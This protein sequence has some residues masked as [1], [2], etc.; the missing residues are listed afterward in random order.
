M[1]TTLTGAN[2]YALKRELRRVIDGFV[3]EN[4]DFEQLR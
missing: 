4:G 3:K 1:T 2:R